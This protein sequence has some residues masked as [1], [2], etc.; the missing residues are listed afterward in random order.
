MAASTETLRSLLKD[1]ALHGAI[2]IPKKKLLW[3]LGWAQD[4]AGAWS[5]LLTHW[6]EIE[7]QPLHGIEVWD[8]IVLSMPTAGSF[9]PVSEWAGEK[10]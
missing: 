8:K 9:V 2:I 6:H 1:V 5:D 10:K 3:L 4:R 7:T